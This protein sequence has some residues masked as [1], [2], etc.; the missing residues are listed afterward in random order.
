MRDARLQE[1]R[2]VYTPPL[3][4]LIEHLQRLPGIGPKSAQRL[5]LHILNRPEAEIEAL[6]QSLVD[7]KKQVGQCSVCF[8][9]SAEPVCNICRAPNRDNQTI[10]VVADSRDVIALEKTREYRGKYH[11]LGGLISPMDGIGPEQLTIQPLVRRVSQQGTGEV[12]LAI[13]PSVEGETTTLYLGHLLKPFTKVT[14]IAFGLP[15]GGD[16]EYADEVTLARA[17]EGRREF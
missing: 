2:T 4:R 14:R 13:S 15:M 6:A 7:A 3:A 16:L 17:L 12:I 8:H 9:L 5:A 11:V 1:P 10:C